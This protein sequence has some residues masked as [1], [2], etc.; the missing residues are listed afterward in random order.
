[1]DTYLKNLN[2]WN[3]AYSCH[4]IYTDEH[5][6]NVL[7]IE[8]SVFPEHMQDSLEELTDFFSDEFAHGLLLCKGRKPVG[9]LKGQHLDES[10]TPA[11]LLL[12][13][14][15]NGI[16]DVTFYMDSV[17]ILEGVRSTQILDFLMHEM[18]VDMRRFDYQFVAAHARKKGG[19][20]R[21]YQRRY[22]AKVLTTYE[23]WCDFGEAFDYILVDLKNVPVQSPLRRFV[24]RSM[25]RIFS[26]FQ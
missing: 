23:N 10:N 21:L 5:V 15:L 18:A 1:M 12:Q 20:S 4:T 25:R 22:K 3:L 19:L 8:Q 7:A 6:K 11:E 9:V 2:C 26:W 17:G 24:Y 13:P 14:V 16:R